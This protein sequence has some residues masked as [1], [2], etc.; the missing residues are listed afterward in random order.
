MLAAARAMLREPRGAL[1][2]HLALV[3]GAA[4]THEQGIDLARCKSHLQDA[5][6]AGL[7]AGGE[8]S[9]KYL[10]AWQAEIA[11]LD[12]IAQ[13][14]VLTPNQSCI[15]RSTPEPSGDKGSMEP[16]KVFLSYSHR[17]EKMTNNLREHLAPMEDD[18]LIEIW[19]DREIEA[20]ADWEGEINRKLVRSD[21]ILLLVSASFLKSDYC[22]KELRDALQKRETGKSVVVPVILRDCD[23][24]STFNLPSY[25]AQALPRDNRPI[26]GGNWPNQDKAFSEVA[27]E[28]RKLFERMRK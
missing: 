6:L 5:V 27:R 15:R 21:V 9:R 11:P 2:L 13:P 12:L 4:D 24:A 23:W 18:G 25:K 10:E 20:G 14:V 19:H 3:S 22:K 16:L 1:N 7:A 17:N 28:L 8:E 26:S